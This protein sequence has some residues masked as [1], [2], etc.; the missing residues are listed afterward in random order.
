MRLELGMC[1]CAPNE[2]EKLSG[3]ER[4]CFQCMCAHL[5]AYVPL[6]HYWPAAEASHFPV[7][8]KTW[9]IKF[10]L[11]SIIRTP[12]INQRQ[13]NQCIPGLVPGPHGS[14]GHSIFTA[15]IIHG[16]LR[17]SHTVHPLACSWLLD[18]NVP[19]SWPWS[20]AY[21]GSLLK[22]VGFD[23]INLAV[24]ERS[25]EMNAMF[26]LVLSGHEGKAARG[27]QKS[28]PLSS[29]G[30]ERLL[31]KPQISTVCQCAADVSLVMLT[32]GGTWQRWRTM[33]RTLIHTYIQTHTLS[34]WWV[35]YW[36]GHWDNKVLS[37][38]QLY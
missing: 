25:E 33:V 22:G 5:H 29:A 32:C 34:E 4:V 24:E 11:Q 23:F 27:L 7:F 38:W 20:T 14:D 15:G 16:G 13:L 3:G 17:W 18:S 26:H 19:R 2:S 35:C 8:I 10:Y 30:R 6:F 31:D 9:T 1:V 37:P 21:G 36:Q 12:Q 28:P